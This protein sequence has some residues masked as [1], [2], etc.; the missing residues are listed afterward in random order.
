MELK[1]LSTPNSNLTVADAIFGCEFKGPLIHQVVTSYLTN[2]RSGTKAQKTR[3]EVRGGGA[4]P[5]KQKGTGR[6]RAGS[7]RSPIWRGGGVTFAAKPRSFAQKINKKMYR[8]ALR[9]ILSEL[10]RQNRL[11]VVDQFVVKSNKTKDFTQQ[12]KELGLKKVLIVVE[13]VEQNLYLAARNLHKVEVCDVAG[14]NP[15]NLIAY[16]QVLI[17]VPAIKKLEE[18]LQ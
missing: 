11:L 9:S 16:D 2:A 18:M 3:A 4:K 7:I 12:L 8:V 13:N 5:W 15:V 10:L 6:A 1:L 14:I 17:T